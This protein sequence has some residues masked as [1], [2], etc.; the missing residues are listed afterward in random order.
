M[1]KRKRMEGAVPVRGYS[2]WKEPHLFPATDSALPTKLKEQ[3][4]CGR[5]YDAEGSG[6]DAVFAR[7]SDVILEKVANMIKT[8]VPRNDK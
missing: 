1:K 2:Y 3:M 7:W 4:N 8:L 6:G 5:A